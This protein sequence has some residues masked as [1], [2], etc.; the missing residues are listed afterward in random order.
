[1]QRKAL[2]DDEDERKKKLSKIKKKIKK[3]KLPK[4]RLY[5]V[6]NP[7]KKF[8]EKWTSTRSRLNFPHPLRAVICGVPNSGKGI[9]VM[10]IILNQGRDEK[11]GENKP[12]E[13][14]FIV[15]V[16]GKNT[17]EYKDCGA[18]FLD[19]IPSPDSWDSDRKKLLILEDISFQ[20]LSKQQREYWKR[21]WAYC[22]THK[23]LSC[24][25]TCQDM[26]DL[27]EIL[28]RRCTSLFVLFP[29]VDYTSLN[30]I[31][32]KVGLRKGEL[33]LLF[34]K[35]AKNNHT[36][37]WLDM[38]GDGKSPYKIRLNGFQTLTRE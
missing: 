5:I 12:F 7:D 16:D 4:D 36:S 30:T 17:K 3:F 31:N 29:S 19:K 28:V 32:R 23:N 35:Y 13:D 27:S 1:M 15:H 34:Q 24:I 26:Y 20:S 9:C 11:K 18:I 21:A 10:N 38:T 33:E 8:H 14:I 6:Q 25:L 2:Y 22:S 37:I